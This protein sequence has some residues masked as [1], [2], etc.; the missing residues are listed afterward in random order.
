[1]KAL[2][3]ATERADSKG[4]ASKPAGRRFSGEELDGDE[5][6]RRRRL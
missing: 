3:T 2:D 4:Q 1:M 5:L 6:R